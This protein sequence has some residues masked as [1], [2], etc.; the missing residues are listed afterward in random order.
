MAP[1]QNCNC[2]AISGFCF[3]GVAGTLGVA[4]IGAAVVMG[5]ISEMVVKF[6]DHIDEGNAGTCDL[7]TTFHDEMRCTQ[8]EATA[9]RVE[10]DD[11]RGQGYYCEYQNNMFGPRRYECPCDVTRKST[12]FGMSGSGIQMSFWPD[13][14]SYEFSDYDSVWVRD[15]SWT[16][17]DETLDY[18]SSYQCFYT[19]KTADFEHMFWLGYDKAEVVDE[20]KNWVEGIDSIASA[21]LGGGIVCLLATICFCLCG[22]CICWSAPCLPKKTWLVMTRRRSNEIP[23]SDLHPA[24]KKPS[25]R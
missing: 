19:A 22:C 8:I 12:G 17:A 13:T 6:Q 18:G 9:P 25:T 16:E 24:G 15:I 4:A 14:T 10:N 5:R 20:I 1:N 2:M 7:S 3:G 11:I 23:V 21:C